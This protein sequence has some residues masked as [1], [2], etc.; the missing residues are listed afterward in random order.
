MHSFTAKTLDNEKPD[1]AVAVEV[2]K[3]G[4]NNGIVKREV[5]SIGFGGG[6]EEEGG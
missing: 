4:D 3:V 1:G 2:A 5:V 6:G